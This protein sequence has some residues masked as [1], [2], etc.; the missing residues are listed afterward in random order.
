MTKLYNKSELSFSLVFI[1]I[2]IVGASL[3]DA[4]SD[5]L[6]TSKVLTFPFLLALSLVLFF[7]IKRNKL[8]TKYGLCKPDFSSKHFL[9]YLPL[10]FLISTNMWFGLKLNLSI[11]ESILNVLAMLLVGFVEEI[12]FRGF[13]FKSLEKENLKLAITISSI[14][15]G[16]GHIINLFLNGQEHL[17]SNV[18]QVF[19]AMAVGFLFVIMFYKGKSLIACILTHSL[20]N[21]LS[22]FQNTQAI[23]PL[24]EILISVAIIVVSICYAIILLKTLTPN[25]K[26][27]N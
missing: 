18:C 14:T 7:W 15:F 26:K 11:I 4:F 25:N 2:Y 20:V 23:Q 12:I 17:L 21:A 13:L 5:M 27:Q 6:K 19:Y 3:C 1:G 10:L 16:F 22:V 8:T 24:T 9:F